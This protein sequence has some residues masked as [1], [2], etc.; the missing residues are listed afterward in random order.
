MHKLDTLQTYLLA[1][2]AASLCVGLVDWRTSR[3][4]RGITPF[5]SIAFSLL[6]GAPAMLIISLVAHGRTRKDNVA[7][8]FFAAWSLIAWVLVLAN[9]YGWHRFDC[10]RLVESLGRSHLPL[11][12]FL[13]VMNALTFVLFC[14]DKGRARRDA[15]RIGEGVL[16]G[17]SLFGGALGGLL[18]ML[19]AHHKVRTP[20]FRIGLP[21]ALLL[22]LAVIAYLLQA[23]LV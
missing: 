4:G 3:H 21:L 10:A 9:V 15:W 2:N 11:W 8:R 6:G 13:G 22:D 18:G 17:L 20:Y 12:I 5:V 1:I 16:L 14:V 7:Q 19:L 23:G